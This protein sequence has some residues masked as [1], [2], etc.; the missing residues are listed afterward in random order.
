M[1]QL[2]TQ[3]S[4]LLFPPSEETLL[5]R[6]VQPA[7]FL[8]CYRPQ[9]VGT[10]WYLSDYQNK[11]VQAAIKAH[12]FQHHRYAKN[13]LATLIQQ[14][15]TEQPN[16]VYF[17]PIPLSRTRE[18]ERGYNQVTE[19]LQSVQPRP[20]ICPALTRIVD[21]K[22]QTHLTKTER[23]QNVQG[24]FAVSRHGTR[25][26]PNVTVILTDDVLSTG[27]T[28]AAAR[29]TLAPHLPPSCTLLSLALAH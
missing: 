28:M 23:L 14:W 10:T 21:T 3:L 5:L 15:L 24:A 12:K 27:A 29:A 11:L 26:S 8:R 19:I 6:H 1:R 20:T 7:Q 18:R 17:V 13:L 2:L 4:D 25:I 9:Q 22:P 16:D